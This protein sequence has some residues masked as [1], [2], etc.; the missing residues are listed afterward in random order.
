M[1]FSIP[2]GIF[3]A[4]LACLGVLA[5]AGAASAEVTSSQITSPADPFHALPDWDDDTDDEIDIAGT[6]VVDGEDDEDY[7]DVRCYGWDGYETIESGVEVVEGTFAVEDA[8]LGEISDNACQLRAVPTDTDSY[9]VADF[10]GPRMFV[11]D[12]IS[13]EGMSRPRSNEGLRAADRGGPLGE[14]MNFEFGTNHAKGYWYGESVGG[15]GVTYN[16]PAFGG[17]KYKDYGVFDSVA[18]LYSQDDSGEP[19]ISIDGEPAATAY[20]RRGSSA[21]SLVDGLKGFAAPIAGLLDAPTTGNLGLTETD[22]LATCTEN[23]GW[24]YLDRLLL[25]YGCTKWAGTGV[26]FTRT[27]ATSADGALLTLTDRYTST[28]GKAHELDLRYDNEFDYYD[29]YPL[30][31]FDGGPNEARDGYD[32]FSFSKSP[33]T[34]VIDGSEEEAEESESSSSGFI[35]YLDAPE[36]IYFEDDDAYIARYRRTVP[37]NGSTTITQVLG[38]APTTQQAQALAGIVEDKQI[39]PALS[40]DGPVNGSTT[41]KDQVIVRGRATDDLGIAALTVNGDPVGVLGDGS[42]QTL[43]SLKPGVNTI[44]AKARDASGNEASAST[45]VIHT[46][47]AAVAA[48][49]SPAVKAAAKCT[50]P[51][52]RRRTLLSAERALVRAG[53]AVGKLK[54]KRTSALKPGRVVTQSIAPGQIVAAGTIVKLVVSKKPLKAK[55]AERRKKAAKKSAR[56][57]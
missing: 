2:R 33:T 4:L 8:Y 29:S 54:S 28:D 13:R 36:R 55:K 1:L 40:I 49:A 26:R 18:A 25:A 16:Y 20:A 45:D 17:L 42:W 47:V 24:N 9:D 53:C 5:F 34:V 15:G 21:G 12:G 19:E 32:T 46:P 57:R 6:A 52:V 51:R 14:I 35:T 27:F 10:K 30:F 38:Q 11:G 7:V 22:D 56:R 43:M 39:G 44:T 3:I 37:A 23:G 31:G 41:D 48:A 50:V